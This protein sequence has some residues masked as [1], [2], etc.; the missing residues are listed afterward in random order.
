M[1]EKLFKHIGQFREHATN[2]FI[3]IVNSLHDPLLKDVIKLGRQSFDSEDAK[4]FAD[5]TD[6]NLFVDQLNSTLNLFQKNQKAVYVYD[7]IIFKL[8]QPNELIFT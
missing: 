8:S 6:T 4:V 5:E 1:C 3:N 7:N 2:H